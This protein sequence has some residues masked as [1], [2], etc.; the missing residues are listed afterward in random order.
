MPLRKREIKYY[1]WKP[2]L[3]SPNRPK[4]M[5]YRKVLETNSLPDMVDLR[6]KMPGVYDQNELGSCVSNSLAGAVQYLNGG[7]DFYVPSRL[8]IYYNA[9]VIEGS[10]QED[11]GASIAD[12]VEVIKTLGCPHESMWWYDIKKFAVK[13]SHKVYEDALHCKV[14]TALSIDNTNVDEIRTCLV[15]KFPVVFGFTVYESFEGDVVS[16]TGVVPLPGAHE[17][18][19]GGHAVLIVGFLHSQRQFIVRNSWGSDWGIKGYC[20]MPYS[21]VT[22]PELA[23]DFWAIEKMA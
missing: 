22:N 15:N 14:K 17:M 19:L 13:P 11:A 16:R 8:F 23:G 2:P 4:F 3:P 21:Y 20:L 7:H 6:P 1:G 5:T 18:E 12:G 10:V 9:R